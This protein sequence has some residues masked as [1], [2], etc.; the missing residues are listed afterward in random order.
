MIATS[1]PSRRADEPIGAHPRAAGQ[2]DL[3]QLAGGEDLAGLH[4]VAGQIF[5]R[6]GEPLRAQDHYRSAIR[7][8][9]ERGEAL[10]GQLAL[11]INL[12]LP[13]AAKHL[14]AAHPANLAHRQTPVDRTA[15][16]ARQRDALQ[17]FHTDHDTVRRPRRSF[18]E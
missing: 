14:L 9:P 11:L 13:V 3:E 15:L 18:R 12:G 4:D 8:A 16:I 7:L 10:L 5:H 1:G 2:R 17:L 6:L